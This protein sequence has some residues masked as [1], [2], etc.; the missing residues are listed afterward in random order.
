MELV[1]KRSV[2]KQ[3]VTLTHTHVCGQTP[4]PDTNVFLRLFPWP[5]E[6]GGEGDGFASTIVRSTEVGV[7]VWSFCQVSC[8]VSVKS[9]RYLSNVHP[10]SRPVVPYETIQRSVSA[11]KFSF[12]IGPGERG[13]QQQLRGFVTETV[14]KT[15]DLKLRAN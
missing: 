1:T 4:S 11:K 2:K 10:S 8:G 5:Y 6:R 3:S 9:T 15:R 7:S 14:R 12:Y 13:G